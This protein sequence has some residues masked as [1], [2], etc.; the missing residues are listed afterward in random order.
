MRDPEGI[1]RALRGAESVAVCSHINPDGDTI[2]AALAMRLMLQGMG[3]RVQVFCDSKLPDNLSFLP[4]AEEI[5]LPDGCEER[6]DLFLSVDVSDRERLGRCAR[7][8]SQCAHTAQID[9]HGSNP[10]V[11]ECNSLDG[12]ASATCVL[13]LEQAKAMGIRLNREMA[14]CLYAGIS[15]DTGNFSFECTDAETFRDAA[16]LREAGLPLAGMSYRLF[17]EKS[18]PHLR[19]L[20][21]AIA[22][23][24]FRG[25]QEEIAVMTLNRQDFADCGALSEHA[26]TIVN[27][28][29]ET[30]G[31]RMAVL[32]RESE[33]GRIKFSLRAV[34]PLCVDDV[35][36]RLGGG[37][38]AQAAG[39]SMA[40][41]LE[42]TTERVVNEMIRE[43]EK[44]Q[45]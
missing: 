24:R 13:I 42:E 19:L 6:F 20:G 43:L 36:V 15:T 39:I 28:G 21:R 38:H 3:K 45:V 34:A 30:V 7:L 37:G 5:R 22:S 33:D 11:M 18:R 26:D 25:K 31:T 12:N 40:G 9:H 17:R 27:Y 44:K 35:A 16:E 23:L 10:M 41:T 8:M 4:G 2:G 29:L 32:G 1:A 14:I